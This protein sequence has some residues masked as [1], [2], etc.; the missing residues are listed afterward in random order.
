V[1]VAHVNIT[2]K[3]FV[4]IMLVAISVPAMPLAADTPEEGA[5]APRGEFKQTVAS[6]VELKGTGNVFSDSTFNF[7]IPA[8]ATILSASVDME[9]KPVV[10][11]LQS[12]NYD[13]ADTNNNQAFTGTYTSTTPGNKNP[14]SFA[15]GTMT[16]YE[17]SAIYAIDGSVASTWGYGYNGEYAFHHF[18]FKTPFDMIENVT[19]TY[20]GYGGYTYYGGTCSVYVYIWNNQSASWESVGTCSGT[21]PVTISKKFTGAGYI[22]QYKSVHILAIGQQVGGMYGDYNN[23][24]SDCCKISADGRVLTY[25]KNPAM[26]VGANGR[27]EWSLTEEKFNYMVSIGD[28]TLM[29]EIQTLVR[30]ATTQNVSIKVKI[31]SSSPG[32]VRITNFTVAF[33]AAPWC[34]GVPDTFSLN[35]DS[36]AN[37]LIDLNQYFTDDRDQNKLMFEILYQEDAKKVT[38]SLDI[39]GHSLNF[40]TA[41]NNWW[42]VE[43][44]QMRATDSDGLTRDSNVFRVTVNSVND[45]PVIASI[46][47]QIAVQGTA[48]SMQ[49]KIRDVDMELDTDEAVTYSD[50]STLFDIDPTT[51]RCGFTPK[52]EQVGTYLIMITAVD[53]Y[54]GSDTENFTLEVQDAEDMPVLE[55]VPDQTATE[56]QAFIYQCVAT[57][58]DVPYGDVLTFTDNSPLFVIGPSNGEISFTP[59]QK[60]IGSHKVTVTVTDARG[61]VAS[62]EFTLNVLNSMGT[63][64]KP[65]TIDAIPNQTAYEDVLFEY[66]VKAADPDI[67]TGDA[68]SFIDNCAVFDINT[69]TGKISFKPTA[70]DAGTLTI[71]VTVKDRE[72]LTAETTFVLTV[73]KANHAPNITSVNPKAG[74]KYDPNKAITLSTSA[75]DP[76]G[77]KLNYTWKDGENVLGNGPTLTVSFPDPGTYVITLVVTDGKIQVVNETTIEINDPAVKPKPNNGTTPGFEG[78]FLVA[79]LGLVTLLVGL[80]RKR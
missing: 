22:D 56:N 69:N 68:L 46:P 2:K 12:G 32:K 5:A 24:N 4:L 74:T 63:M 65:P 38:C 21:T 23:I 36:I 20:A 53:A 71:K 39:D 6:E 31:S 41:T 73:I 54:Q 67:D 75:S 3:I 72:G 26:D 60:D 49:V 77:D 9:G 52:Q 43:K 50:N 34:L 47:K 1:E 18:K 8:N 10:G 79:A 42:G 14:S 70:K 66:T 17:Y 62:H 11:P 44:F 64:N 35:E 15:G 37:K 7:S 33:N 80:N 13:F 40:K 19:A 59:V 51:G 25:P 78:L 28:V 27:I 16:S 61:G 29:N 76:D 45:N 57:D 55:V 48:W 58:P 30:S